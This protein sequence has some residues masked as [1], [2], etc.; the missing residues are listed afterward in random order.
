MW[1][2]HG[3]PPPLPLCPILHPSTLPRSIFFVS[4]WLEVV[5]H[6]G[7]SLAVTFRVKGNNVKKNCAVSWNPGHPQSMAP[8][9]GPGG[10]KYIIWS[11]W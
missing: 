9:Y 11:L 7:A 2:R 3:L 1:R 5:L 10:T 6:P 4:G 8:K